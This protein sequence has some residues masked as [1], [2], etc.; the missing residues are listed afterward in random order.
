MASRWNPGD[1]V[2]L[3]EIWRGRVWSGRPVTVAMDEQDLLGLYIPAGA[4]WKRP[5]ALDEGIL[6]L[7]KSEWTLVDTRQPIDALRLA[8]PGADHSVLLLWPEG[9]GDL[10]CWYVNLEE[11]LRRTPRGFDYMDQTLDIVISP[12]F[13]DWHWKDEDE[14]AEAVSLGLIS[15]RRA[16]ELRAEGERVVELMEGRKPPFDVDWGHW[17]PEETWPVP[18]LPSGWDEL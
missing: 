6:R 16:R 3:R 2:V 4:T 11:P 1:Q 9:H 10:T 15:G 14:L 5:V 7:P 12:D 8:T 18:E 17:R 13:S